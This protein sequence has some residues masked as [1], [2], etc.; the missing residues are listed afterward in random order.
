[1]VRRFPVGVGRN[2]ATPRGTFRIANKITDPD[3]YNRG[4]VVEA[5]SPLNPLGKRWMGLGMGGPE[6]PATSYG[7]HPTDDA[8]ATSASSP[9][10]VTHSSRNAAR[11]ASG[12]RR[13]IAA[14]HSS[15]GRHH[16][17]VIF[18]YKYHVVLINRRISIIPFYCHLRLLF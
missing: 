1:M 17:Q 4:E 18:A 14:G 6:N 3:W 2:D 11:R 5:G 8:G 16:P 9:N 15:S 7:L 10:A 12:V 13:P